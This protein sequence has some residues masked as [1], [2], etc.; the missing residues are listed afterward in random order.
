[1]PRISLSAIVDRM[2]YRPRYTAFLIIYILV[3]SIAPVRAEN[4]F[5]DN[6][7]GT[8]TDQKAGLMWAKSD[9]GH[10]ISWKQAQKWTR[11][12]FPKTI[13]QKYGNW[14]LPTLRELQTLHEEGLKSKAYQAD[15]GFEVKIVKQIR[16][17]CTIIWSSETAMGSPLAFNFYLGSAFAIDILDNE[18]C[19]VL[20]VRN[21]K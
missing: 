4:R 14:R 20:P 11:T 17:S 21:L 13:S 8:V 16:P 18:G 12:K 15:C 5:I 3:L 19:R 9:N 2:F 6:G 10:D 7:D 1:M